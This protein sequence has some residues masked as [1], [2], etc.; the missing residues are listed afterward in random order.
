M[1]AIELRTE[2]L[3]NPLGIGKTRPNLFWNCEGGV[4][5]SA[6]RILARRPGGQEIWDS[7]KSSGAEMTFIPWKGRPLKSRD[8]VL[9]K[10]LVWDEKDESGEWSE[11]AVFEIGLL[12][13]GDW[14]AKWISGDYKPEKKRRYPADC[15]QKK[16]VLEEKPVRARIYAS[17]RGVYESRLNGG[18][19][20]DFI[21]APGITDYRKRIQCQTYDVTEL[22][23]QG[24]NVWTFE[25]ADGWYRGSVGAWGTTCFYGTR[26]GVIGQLELT[27]PDGKTVTVITDSSFAWSNDGPVRFADNKDGEKIDANRVPSYSGKAAETECGVIPTPS[28]NVPVRERERFA[29]KLILTPSG[30]KV[31]DFG[32]N[33]SG[34]L[35]FTVHAKKGDKVCLRFGEMLDR[36]GEFTQKN[37]QCSN[38]HKT[39]PLQEV[40]YLCKDGRNCYK[41]RFATFGFR[42]VL[43][44]TNADCSAADFQA[45]A[46]YSDMKQKTEFTSS[47]EL[48]NRFVKNTIWS[49]K[50][51]STDLPTDC[52]TRER[53]GWSGDAQIFFMTAGYLVDYAAFAKKYVRDLYDNQEKNGKLPQIVP[54][55]GQ[56]FYMAPLN[57]S[58]G[59]ADAGILIPYR[60]WK[61]YGDEGIVR[62]Y[63]EG[64]RKYARF[65]MGRCGKRGLLAKRI[66]LTGPGKRYLVNKGQSYGE[67]AEPA[68]VYP[69]D[70][71]D[72]AAPHA[73]VSTAYTSHMMSL[74]A[75]IAEFLGK[76][77]DA[78]QFR[79]YEKGTRL[80]YQE[81]V[82]Q[83]DFSL[84]TD[85]QALLVR[86]LAF[87]LLTVEQTEYA[88]NRLLQALE[89][90]GWRLG[91]GFLSTPLILDVLAD[92]DIEAAYRLLENEEMPGWLFMPKHGAATVWESWEGTESQKGIAS[93]NHYS[94]GA[95]CE[96]LFR[97]MCGIQA[98]GKRH[99]RIAPRP[100]GNFTYAETVYD[101]IYGRVSCGWK[102]EG[103]TISYTAAVPANCTAEI[104]LPGKRSMTVETGEYRF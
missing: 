94:K 89:H 92:I 33:I 68:D 69:Q 100:G 66:R 7:G 48:L 5:Q 84:D 53:H 63:Y 86:P 82:R 77:E 3:E 19:A 78:E 18:R 42:Y 2:Q 16:F 29:A 74:M 22:L 83:P 91:T 58:V 96:W 104:V 39:T 41:T 28:D 55:G 47:N 79:I 70:W 90:Y 24:E 11:E 49:L 80:A 36:N 32:Q 72:I 59:W 102:K 101:S 31:L 64:M 97:V 44:E 54:P 95:V 73:E 57:G 60:M 9:W 25:L 34:Y 6:W 30:K 67:W 17:A 62:E 56:D 46:V 51:N 93:L 81:L 61:L 98:A 12:G 50:G 40:K 1:K 87:H 8:T 35:T 99:F 15:F 4:R 20:G 103:E 21:M 43:V 45:I 88:G 76:K 27:L 10:V 13:A 26:T 38:R 85:R 75:E 14:K 23:R 65:M 37:I 52:P 71:K